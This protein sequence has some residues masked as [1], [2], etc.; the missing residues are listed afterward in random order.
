MINNKCADGDFKHSNTIVLR[1]CLWGVESRQGQYGNDS[2]LALWVG[3]FGWLVGVVHILL[4]PAIGRAV[5]SPIS[6]ILTSS[7]SRSS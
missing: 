2:L 4:T 6:D 5:A 1:K 7:G 3:F